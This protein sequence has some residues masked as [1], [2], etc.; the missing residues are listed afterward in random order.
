MTHE[1]LRQAADDARESATNTAAREAQLAAALEVAREELKQGLRAFDALKP[2]KLTESTLG[3]VERRKLRVEALE[4]QL[5]E[6]REAA[7]EAGL[8][9]HFADRALA[10][11]EKDGIG[12]WM[13]AH[14]GELD[15]IKDALR[16]AEEAHAEAQR[17]ADALEAGD[18]R[19]AALVGPVKQATGLYPGAIASAAEAAAEAAFNALVAHVRSTLGGVPYGKRSPEEQAQKLTH[20]LDTTPQWQAHPERDGIVERI[21]KLRR[22]PPPAPPPAPYDPDAFSSKTRLVPTNPTNG[23]IRVS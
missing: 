15:A 1:S 8:R 19:A 14:A 6:A 5:S 23:A 17:I 11:F 7:K 22:T 9:A 20:A 3:D 16:R 12:P 2:S 10:D 4:L 18:A 13:S 21:E